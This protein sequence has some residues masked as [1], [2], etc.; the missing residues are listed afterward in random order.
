MTIGEDLSA[1][2]SPHLSQALCTTPKIHNHFAGIGARKE[3]N[4]RLTRVLNTVVHGFF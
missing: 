2:R 4:K 3:T 1:A